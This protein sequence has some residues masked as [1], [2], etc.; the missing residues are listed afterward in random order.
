MAPEVNL[1]LPDAELS[2][3]SVNPLL[4]GDFVFGEQ[5]YGL[6]QKA[7]VGKTC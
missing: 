3:E 2:S 7:I 6:G 4:T 1:I 5:Y